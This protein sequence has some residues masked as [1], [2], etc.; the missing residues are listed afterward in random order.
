MKNKSAVLVSSFLVVIIVLIGVYFVISSQIDANYVPNYLLEDFIPFPEKSL[1]VN[2]YKVVT[3]SEEDMIKNYFNSFVSLMLE[4]IDEAY[5]KLDDETKLDIYKDINSFR[6]K[7]EFIT[8]DYAIVPSFAEYSVSSDEDGKKI[9]IVKD[10]RNN[11]YRFIVEAVMKYT[12]SL[13]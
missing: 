6:I 13:D 1:G 4:N 9:Y 11:I 3:V 7:V 2:E 5:E 12:V 10:K 8:V